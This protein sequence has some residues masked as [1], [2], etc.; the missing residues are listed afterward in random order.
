M[1][2]F[3]TVYI[4]EKNLIIYTAY[5]VIN[6]YLVSDIICT[7]CELMKGMFALQNAPEV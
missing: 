7:V 5:P 4:S 6:E 1:L 3:Y 2:T